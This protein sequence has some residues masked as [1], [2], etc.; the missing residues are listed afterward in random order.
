MK[1]CREA[2]AILLVCTMLILAGCDSPI[3][4]LQSWFQEE[5]PVSEVIESAGDVQESEA[6]RDT[7][8]YYKDDKGFLVPVMRKLP[9]TDGRG[10][11]KTALKAMIDTPAN[12][13]DVQGIGLIPVIPA[14]TE[15]R[16]MTIRDGV[17]KV[18]FSEDFL[19]Y[20]T[21]EEEMALIQAVAYT[22]LEFATID[23]VQILVEGKPLEKLKYGTSLAEL[24]NREQINYLGD[25]SGNNRTIVYFEG[26]TNGL[27]TYF[28]PVTVSVETQEG[29][30]PNILDALDALVKG[31]PSES[32]L[33]T[34]I[35]QGTQ[36]ISV[37]MH[38]GI[39]NVNVTEEILQVVENKN[40]IESVAKAFGLTI[41]EHY[42]DVLGVKI[43]VN[44]EEIK[45]EGVVQEEPIVVPAFANQY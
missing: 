10:I 2:L 22:L 41:R 8:L 20:T 31:P 33:F 1:R 19:N 14:N 23:S 27:E 34:S 24:L 44:G 12:R 25:A 45:S 37:D 36:V 35:P 38:N 11:A 17:C 5:E 29:S 30:K 32:G 6:L 43:L 15:I 3:S 9:W 16:G 13:E 18:D 28:V 26:T 40:V 42:P 7:V 39:A 21:K 4:M